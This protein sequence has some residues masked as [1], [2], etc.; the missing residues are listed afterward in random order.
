MGCIGCCTQFAEEKENMNKTEF[1][2]AIKESIEERMDENVEVTLQKFYKNNNVKRLGL[3]VKDLNLNIAPTLYLDELYDSYKKGRDLEEIINVV[4]DNLEKGMPKSKIDLDFFMEYDKVKDKICHKLI[5]YEKNKKLLESVPHL[6]FL[7]LAICFF[8]P[9]YHEDIG[10]GSI[11]IRNVH[12]EKW[13][14]NTSE[15]WRAAKENTRKICPEECVS[16]E[17]LMMDLLGISC[18]R[19]ECEARWDK[20]VM[21]VLTNRQRSF[22]A[23]VILYDGLLGEIADGLDSNLFIIPSSIHEVL[24]LPQIEGEEARFEEMIFDVNRNELDPQEVL[25]DHLYVYDRAEKK[26]KIVS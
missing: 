7:D 26:V 4:Y 15:L 12:V 13:G 23:S 22:G 25:S 1:G 9:F 20:P 21:K 14:I 2:N 6:P 16:M 8:Y 3:V 11:L 19:E 18:E 10:R 5:N 24:L 17:R